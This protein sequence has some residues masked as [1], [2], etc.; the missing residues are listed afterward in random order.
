MLLPRRPV[1]QGP[2]RQA[3]RAGDRRQSSAGGGCINVLRLIDGGL[4]VA[5]PSPSGAA[6]PSPSPASGTHTPRRRTAAPFTPLSTGRRA[7]SP[8]LYHQTRLW[9]PPPPLLPH[10]NP[11]HRPLCLQEPHRRGAP[12]PTG[13]PQHLL[14]TQDAYKFPLLMALGVVHGAAPAGRRRDRA[15][16]SHKAKATRHEARRLQLLGLLARR[17]RLR[18]AAGGGRGVN[19]K[20]PTGSAC[21]GPPLYNPHAPLRPTVRPIGPQL[22]VYV[23]HHPPATAKGRRRAGGEASAS[24]AAASAAAAAAVAAA[25]PPYP[26]MRPALHWQRGLMGWWAAKPTWMAWTDYVGELGRRLQALM[27]LRMLRGGWG[28]GRPRTLL[29]VWILTGGAVAASVAAVAV[30]STN[31]SAV[32]ES[33]FCSTVVV[34]VGVLL[35]FVFVEC[36]YIVCLVSEFL[37]L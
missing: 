17:P 14:L 16:G 34:C 9:I 19:G 37:C 25:R 28:G 12:R 6:S 22:P 7:T 2:L 5:H 1:R 13:P 3:S 26:G 33:P 29:S 23:R 10:P 8:P 21:W 11:L 20:T 27:F 18:L 32:S 35:V 36:I 4:M 15:H 31:E 30:R 24:A